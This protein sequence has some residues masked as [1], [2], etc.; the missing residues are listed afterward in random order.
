MAQHGYTPPH[1]HRP[2]PDMTATEDFRRA[3]DAAV[4]QK[5]EELL[6]DLLGK[7][8]AANT[9]A[10]APPPTADDK[11]SVGALALQLAELTGQGNGKVY[12]A[13]ELVERRRKAH[14]QMVDIIIELRAAKQVPVYRLVNKVFLKMGQGLGEMVIDPI[15]RDNDKILRPQEI[16]W[17]GV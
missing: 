2:A 15:Y 1:Q 7:L 17:P 8:A 6:P 5:L 9:G 14:E 10:G 16:N 11:I 13:P 3:V 12:V 4:A